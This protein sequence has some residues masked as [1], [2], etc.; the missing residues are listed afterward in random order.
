AGVGRHGP[1]VRRDDGSAVA[2]VVQR[3]IH[4]R[5]WGQLAL[6]SVERLIDARA[7]DADVL[8][9]FRGRAALRLCHDTFSTSMSLSSRIVRIVRS[10][11]RL[12]GFRLLWPALTRNRPMMAKT[13]ATM[14]AASHG[15]TKLDSPITIAWARTSKA[16]K[17]MRNPARSEIAPLWTWTNF[18]PVSARAR[19]SS[20]RN[21]SV[22]SRTNSESSDLTDWSV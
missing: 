7:G 17:A 12:S 22:T 18:S 2:Y 8:L 15:S 14:T 20:W 10:G 3:L 13:T 19:R 9:D 4:K 16:T 11:T 21:S 1:H 5:S 6:E